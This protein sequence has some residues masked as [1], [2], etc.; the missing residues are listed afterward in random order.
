MSGGDVQGG[1]AVWG[2][3]GQLPLLRGGGQAPEGGVAAED[4]QREVQHDWCH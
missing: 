1:G 2:R 4:D 3:E